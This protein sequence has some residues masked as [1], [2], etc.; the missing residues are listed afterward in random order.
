MRKKVRPKLRYIFLKDEVVVSSKNSVHIYPSKCRH[1]SNY[2][3]TAFRY[4]SESVRDL[5]LED[6]VFVCFGSASLVISSVENYVTEIAN[7]DQRPETRKTKA[8]KTQIT[9]NSCTC[10]RCV[11]SC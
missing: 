3:G 7:E 4:D 6:S 10:K 8:T 9:E 11:P 2:V 5:S 1:D